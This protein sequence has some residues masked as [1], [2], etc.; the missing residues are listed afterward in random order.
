MISLSERLDRIAGFV[1]QGDRVADIG[2]DHGY[3]PIYLKKKG[4][5][6]YLVAGDINFGPLEKMEE[7]LEKHLG[8]DREGIHMRQ[9]SGLEVIQPWEVDT[10]VIAGMG[11]LLMEE[12]LD[13]D[14]EKTRSVGRFILQPRNA[15]DKLR[16]WLLEQGFRIV[17]EALVREGRFVWEIICAEPNFIGGG[18]AAGKDYFADRPEQYEVGQRLIEKKDPLLGDF[19][20]NKLRLERSIAENAAKSEQKRA[21]E[22]RELSMRKIE[23]LEGILK[24]VSTERTTDTCD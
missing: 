15:Q 14:P 6:S 4:I 3:I 1:R 18:E 9:G 12:I 23:M 5:S 22:Q 16:R 8:A 13:A 10:V 21:A 17:D 19:I 2:T 24:D 7:N 11:G 20:R